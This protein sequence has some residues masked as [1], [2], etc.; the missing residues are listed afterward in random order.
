MQKQGIIPWTKLEAFVRL[1]TNTIESQIFNEKEGIY[2]KAQ[3]E[4]LL[5]PIFMKLHS[6][7]STIIK[8]HLGEES[9]KQVEDEMIGKSKLRMFINIMSTIR[10]RI[11]PQDL[12]TTEDMT[13]II[14]NIKQEIKVMMGNNI[15]LE[16]I[17]K[18]F[19][20]L[21]ELSD[22]LKSYFDQLFGK[23]EQINEDET[24]IR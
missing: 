24:S 2:T 3:I 17:E 10:L 13:V 8:D 4:T 14:K 21:I 1:Y 9:K 22:N 5:P 11:N 23:M 20:Y 18:T 16:V 19:E 12:R 6:T 15:P 7:L